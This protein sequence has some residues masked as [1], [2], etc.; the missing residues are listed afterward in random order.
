MTFS[1]PSGQARVTLRGAGTRP[2]RTFSRM[3]KSESPVKS[4]SPQMSSQRRIPAAKMSDR[5]SMGRPFTCS[6]D[7]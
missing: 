5:P 7:M 6:G 3:A 2:W 4:F 1:S